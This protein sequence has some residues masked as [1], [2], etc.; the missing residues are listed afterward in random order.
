MK[1]IF[2]I[3][4]ILFSS[5]AVFS[6]EWGSVQKNELT[7]KEIAPIWPGCESGSATDRDDC[8]NQKLATHISKNFRYPADAYKENEEGRVVVDFI[9][10]EQGVIEVT[11]TSGGSSSLQEEAKRNILSI[12]KMVKPGMVGGKPKAIKYTVP[13]TFK[14]GK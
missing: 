5:T 12:P 13:F 7:L 6:Q 2:I 1:K 8:F 10:N 3:S 9:V 14:T 11:K 4:L